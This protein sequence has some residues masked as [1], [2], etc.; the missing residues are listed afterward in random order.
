MQNRQTNKSIKNTKTLPFYKIKLEEP[1]AL[2]LNTAS[3]SGKLLSEMKAENKAVC[4]L[5]VPAAVKNPRQFQIWPKQ[6]I[7]SVYIVALR[8]DDKTHCKG[9]YFSSLS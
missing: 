2:T 8:P 7:E 3:F 6:D 1:R 4:L 5:G 9:H